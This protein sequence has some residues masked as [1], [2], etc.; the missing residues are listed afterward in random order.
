MRAKRAVKQCI[1]NGHKDAEVWAY[2]NPF[3]KGTEKNSYGQYRTVYNP[4]TPKDYYAVLDIDRAFD[5]SNYASRFDMFQ[6]MM[7]A[8]GYPKFLVVKTAP[9]R[10]H[11]LI[12]FQKNIPTKEVLIKLVCNLTNLDYDLAMSLAI[13]NTDEFQKY[14]KTVGI[15]AKYLTQHYSRH[16]IRVPGFI[17]SNRIIKQ[18]FVT[19]EYDESYYTVKSN[20]KMDPHDFADVDA[21]ANSELM[22][23]IW[24]KMN[25]NEMSEKEKKAEQKKIDKEF[26]KKLISNT[27]HLNNLNN[28]HIRQLSKLLKPYVKSKTFAFACY[29]ADN[30]SRL[31]KGKLNIC[32]TAMA[33]K[34]GLSQPQVSRILKKLCGGGFLEVKLGGYYN[35][36]ETKGQKVTKTY[37]WGNVTQ[38]VLENSH[39]EEKIV[40]NKKDEL[41]QPY[42]PGFSNDQFLQDIRN[43]FYL[44]IDEKDAALIIKRKSLQYPKVLRKFNSRAIK[45][46]YKL[47]NQKANIIKKTNP[48]FQ[49]QTKL[50]INTK[51]LILRS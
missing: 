45:S 24:N 39:S 47:W 38:K 29:L 6:S 19:T 32:Q 44:K 48:A 40:K 33:E 1:K 12:N 43:L 30:S 46:A 42:I 16:K 26:A 27:T 36:D 37:G 22:D 51:D 7:T 9:F 17:N 8:L 18:T 10:W 14:M 49:I 21:W 28:K 13:K 50:V 41:L 23:D 5:F 20:Y 4:K 2:V 25:L 34:L 31:K 15:D 3:E 11:V 35:F